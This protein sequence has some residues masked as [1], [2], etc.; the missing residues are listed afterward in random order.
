MK[1]TKTRIARILAAMLCICIMCPCMTAFAMADDANAGIEPPVVTTEPETEPDKESEDTEAEELTPEEK[2]KEYLSSYGLSW[3]ELMKL[4][5]VDENPT[6]TVVTNGGRLNVRTGGGMNYK[7]IDQLLCGEQV[8]VIGRDGDWYQVIIPEKTGYVYSD[9]LSVIEN[10]AGATSDDL[11][12]LAML[13]MSMANPETAPVGL[14]PDGNLTLIDDIGPKKGEGQ[15]FITLESKNGNTF[16]L[17]ID[18]DDKGT[19]NVHFL[20]LVDEAD[21]FAL[22]EDEENGSGTIVQTCTC[23]DKCQPGDVNTLCPVCRTNMSECTGKEP[24]TE[25]EPADDPD[26]EPD[27]EE[28]EQKNGSS[29]IFLI[30]LLMAGGGGAAYY[31]LK[32]KKSQPKSK[33]PVDLDDYDYGEDEDDDEEYE[34]EPDDEEAPADKEE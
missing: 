20:N 1:K 14:T 5:D 4:L 15:Q 19:E 33:G 22:I 34:V 2:L 12:T 24:V 21:L 9:Y 23:T 26:T 32:V 28:P 30:V 10:S 8:K 29:A 6:G 25:T 31:F 11:L 3:D 18:R 13:M 7:V 17:V 27:A 16:Y